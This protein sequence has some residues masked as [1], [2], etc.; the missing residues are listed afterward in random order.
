MSLFHI[1]QGP[2]ITDICTFQFWLIYCGTWGRWIVGYLT[3]V[4]C[5][6]VQSCKQHRLGINIWL[7]KGNEM[8]TWWRHQMEKMI[9]RHRPFVTVGFPSQRPVTP[10][11][12]VSLIWAWTKGWANSRDASDLTRHGANCDVT[13]MISL[14]K[15]GPSLVEI[16]TCRLFRAEPLLEPVLTNSPLDH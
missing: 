7:I 5:C 14:N 16:I 10:S 9:L 2:I 8:Y 1:A 3:L 6:S 4:Y 15:T 13:A 11:F 12:D